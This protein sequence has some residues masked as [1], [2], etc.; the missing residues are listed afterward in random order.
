LAYPNDV[1]A[2][3]VL[4]WGAA[5]AIHLAFGSPAGGGLLSTVGSAI[6]WGL[7]LAVALLLSPRPVHIASLPKNLPAIALIAVLGIGVVAAVVLGLPMLRRTVIPPVAHAAAEVWAAVRSPRRLVLLLGGNIIVALL[8]GLSL[9]A[10]LVAF[11]AHA[12]VWSVIALDVG[13]SAIAALVPISGG[14]TAVSAVGM[15]AGLVALGVAQEAAVGA[16]LANQIVATYLPAIPG[17][18][19]TRDLAKRDWL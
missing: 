12:S 3:L 16:V 8:L 14:G 7:V 11:G 13:I 2:A 10:C 6:G 1:L 15:S 19:A 18:F 4:G 17:W 5:A 9:S